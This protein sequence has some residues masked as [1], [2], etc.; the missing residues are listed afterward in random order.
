M[1]AC[2]T[3]VV[4]LDAA[5]FMCRFA[6]RSIKEKETREYSPKLLFPRKQ[7][8][9]WQH[10]TEKDF[11]RI[12]FLTLS[13]THLIIET[14]SQ[15]PLHYLDGSSVFLFAGLWIASKMNGPQRTACLAK[16]Y[17]TII[18]SSK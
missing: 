16:G 15:Q 5:H 11:V 7:E 6:S 13:H 17:T 18:Y 3:G 1:A 12:L 8:K 10:V 9:T 14:N 4:F 2:H